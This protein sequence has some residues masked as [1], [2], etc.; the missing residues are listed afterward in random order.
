[1]AIHKRVNGDYIITTVDS[2]SNIEMNTNTVTVDG[3]LVVTGQIDFRDVTNRVYVSKNGD[4]TNDGLSWA[5]AKRTIR[6]ACDLAQQLIDQAEYES[7]HVSIFV[8][9]GEYDEICPVTIPEGCALLG[10]SLRSVTVRPTVATSDVFY[11]NSGCY[12]YGITVR[13]HRLN[14]SALDITPEG[15]AGANGVYLPRNTPQTGWAFALAPGSIIR[16]SPYIQN[17]SSISGAGVFGSPEF[18]PGGGGVLVDPSVCAEGN[19]INSIVVDAFTQINLGGIGAKV[20]GRGYMQLVSFFVNMC[21]FGVMCVDGGHVTLLNSNCSFGNYAFW[22]EGLRTLVREPDDD[23]DPEDPNIEFKEVRPYATARTALTNNRRDY[24]IDT[25]NW[26]DAR[27]AASDP[28]FAGFVYDAGTW[29]V[30]FGRVIDAIVQDLLSDSVIFTKIL[31]ETYWDGTVSLLAGQQTQYVAALEQLLTDILADLSPTDPAV[32]PIRH[33]MA[34]LKDSVLNTPNK[35][36]EAARQLIDLN[37]SFLEAEAIAYVDDQYPGLTYRADKCARDVGYI[38]NAVISDLI[39]GTG[40]SGRQAGNAYWRSVRQG[41][42]DILLPTPELTIPSDQTAETVAAIE[43]VRDL[44]LDIIDNVAVTSPY[45]V[46]EP[47][48]LLVGQV[49]DQA[50]LP[51]GADPGDGYITTDTGNFWVWNGSAWTMVGFRGTLENGALGTGSIQRTFTV[52][53]KILQNQPDPDD[54]LFNPM[55]EDA[56]TLLTL[57]RQFLQKETIAYVNDA[58]PTLVYNQDRCERD[59]GYIVDAIIDDLATNTEESSLIAGNAYWRG[60]G[61]IISTTFAAQIEQTVASLDYAK[62]LALKII[63]SDD[64]PPIGLPELVEPQDLYI[65]PDGTRLFVVGGTGPKVFVFDMSV[66]WDISTLVYKTAFDVRA[67]DSTP[68]GVFIGDDGA[69][70]YIVGTDD[71][72]NPNDGRTVYRYVMV[73]PWDVDS[74]VASPSSFDVSPQIQSPSSLAFNSAGST[75]YV[76]GSSDARVFQYTLSNPWDIT[77][78]VF[79]SSLDVSDQI[80]GPAENFPTGIAVGVVNGDVHIYLAGSINNQI[81]DYN[82]TSSG[83]L[84]DAVFVET[85]SIAQQESVISGVFFRPNG[86]NLYIVGSEKDSIVEYSL[87]FNWDITSIEFDRHREIGVFASPYQTTV[88]QRFLSLVSATSDA[89]N[90]LTADTTFYLKPGQEVRFRSVAHAPLLSGL[91]PDQIYY[92]RAIVN[93]TEFTISTTLDGA[94]LT[95][96]TDSGT[97]AVAP[98]GP[99][100]AHQVQRNF[101]QIIGIIRDG[102]QEIEREFG[103]LIEATGYT[104]S[105]AG[106]GIDY[107]K[108]SPGQGGS[109]RSDPNKYTIER[110]GGRVFITATDENG[111]FYVGSLV[112][113]EPGQ[114]ARPLFRINQTGGNIEGRAFYQSIFGFLA[115]FV[116]ALTKRK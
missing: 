84:D 82:L 88:G 57:N 46:L 79:D 41:D 63:D 62:R 18:V 99:S 53:V 71:P 76:V 70:L 116:L 103:S 43:Y 77:S 110:A 32:I 9:S 38:I 6:A 3:N 58:F 7:Y 69:Y 104:L 39:T 113:G 24:Q 115:P 65:K 52:I 44:V 40:R 17:C 114:S 54:I 23:L 80:A 8:A 81:A 30:G 111:D 89:N 55:F 45:Q 109:G 83:D 68:T 101:N 105:Y 2:S 72:E 10:D 33:S 12:V 59:V 73:T 35:P 56:R 94:E 64:T 74:I 87:L 13:G 36:F 37:R 29:A 112:P 31:S 1:M 96:T 107:S 20:V 60:A 85:V 93:T 86:N 27:I 19:R 102:P 26:V 47:Q 108:L 100:A 11:V 25:V 21:Q 61:N 75:M 34:V 90:R 51:G 67:Q 92:I 49:A 95:L 42:D 28:P 22:A 106:A 98:L 91:D 66:A 50:S 4:D 14:P 15:F 78:A 16:V 97:M 48:V 5:K